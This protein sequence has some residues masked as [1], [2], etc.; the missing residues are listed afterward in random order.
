MRWN[1]WHATPGQMFYPLIHTR[2]VYPNEFIVLCFLI[3]CV[4]MVDMPCFYKCLNRI[5][6]A[7]CGHCGQEDRATP[8]GFLKTENVLILFQVHF[9][10]YLIS[11][12]LSFLD[13]KACPENK[14]TCRK[15]GRRIQTPY[16]SIVL[17]Y[18][19]FLYTLLWISKCYLF[20]SNCPIFGILSRLK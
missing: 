13:A 5:R 18:P 14:D 16:A 9:M 1:Q 11:L 17:S 4:S 2:W 10:I 20:L 15:S 3:L 12:Y 7:V 6:N 8:R 19:S